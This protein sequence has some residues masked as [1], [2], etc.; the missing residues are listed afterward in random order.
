MRR[1]RLERHNEIHARHGEHVDASGVPA[2]LQ[3]GGG[4]MPSP[5]RKPESPLG[6]RKEKLASACDK[7]AKGDTQAVKQAAREVCEEVIQKT[8]LPTSRE[9]NGARSLQEVS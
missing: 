4:G 2:N 8:A 9:G 6:D 1:R 5:D 7:A 3:T